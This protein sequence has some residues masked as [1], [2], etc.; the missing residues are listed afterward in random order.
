MERPSS[1]ARARVRI[2]ACATKGIAAE[3][4]II[5]NQKHETSPKAMQL[6]AEFTRAASKK[7]VEAKLPPKSPPK[8]AKPPIP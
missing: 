6:L 5:A 2:A 1:L 4:F 3:K 7:A 8:P